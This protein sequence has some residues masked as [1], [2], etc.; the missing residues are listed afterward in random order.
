MLNEITLMK[1]KMNLNYNS[2]FCMYV[3]YVCF[4]LHI[5]LHYENITYENSQFCNKFM[6]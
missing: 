5:T 3:L 4:V 1:K 6:D 2:G